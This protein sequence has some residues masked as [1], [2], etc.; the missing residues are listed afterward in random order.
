M[1]DGSVAEVAGPDDEGPAVQPFFAHEKT[2][3]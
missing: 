3:E 1:D 2:T